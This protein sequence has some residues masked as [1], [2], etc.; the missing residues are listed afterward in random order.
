MFR[1]ENPGFD[2]VEASV[3]Y[4]TQF[5][6]KSVDYNVVKKSQKSLIFQYK[7]IKIETIERE[8]TENLPKKQ[9]MGVREFWFRK[10]VKYGLEMA[11][12]GV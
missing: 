8:V 4:L 12:A 6:S 1:R 10:K 9:K 3:I 7:S 5:D 11:G 2:G